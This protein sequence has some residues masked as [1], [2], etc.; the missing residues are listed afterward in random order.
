MNKQRIKYFSINKEETR[1]TVHLSFCK[2]TQRD[3][4]KL[5]CLD[6]KLFKIRKTN[7]KKYGQDK[8]T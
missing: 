7:F 2:N 1:N 6:L 5:K 3:N 4:K 8:K